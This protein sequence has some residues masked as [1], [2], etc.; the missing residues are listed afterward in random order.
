[1]KSQQNTSLSGPPPYSSMYSILPVLPVL[2]LLFGLVV[3][4]G[5][6]LYV[7]MYTDT[8]LIN[9]N[10][11]GCHFLVC[12]NWW[13]IKIWHIYY[14][15]ILHLLANSFCCCC[16]C[17]HH[18][19]GLHPSPSRCAPPL[20]PSGVQHAGGGR[21]GK[22]D[23][24]RS[25]CVSECVVHF[26]PFW[27]TQRQHEK[28]SRAYLTSVIWCFLYF[29]VKQDIR[30]ER[31]AGEMRLALLGFGRIVPT[32]VACQCGPITPSVVQ[33]ERKL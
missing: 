6:V 20:P 3:S 7:A 31:N 17:N 27:L 5:L 21:G 33:L 2:L 18:N 10:W 9:T 29:Q 32:A 4:S 11:F 24:D 19:N 16:C 12:I 8:T 25:L 1:M 22:P 30:P 14:R 23:A 13:G 28:A 15:V 26:H